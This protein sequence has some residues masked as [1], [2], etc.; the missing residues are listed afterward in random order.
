E[1]D[2]ILARDWWEKI[3]KY[4][5][6][7]HVAIAQGVRVATHHI[8]R[9]LDEYIVE[10][11]DICEDDLISIDNNIYRTSIIRVLGINLLDHAKVKRE[12]EK[13]GMK[14]VVDKTVI[15]DHIRHG[16]V[17][18]INHA[19][20][21]GLMTRGRLNRLK[22][23]RL[24][25]LSPLRAMHITLKKKSPGIIVVYPLIRLAILKAELKRCG[26]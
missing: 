19:Y 25:L 20:K 26:T 23:F 24:F 11:K 4:M 1:H 15:S 8:L 14:W 6:D 2:V 3:P 13:K 12:I 17:A 22:M 10:R 7:E 5:E 9:K 18:S 16:I 21:M